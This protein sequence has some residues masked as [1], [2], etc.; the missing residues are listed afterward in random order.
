M[1]N[2]NNIKTKLKWKTDLNKSVI[3]ENLHERGWVETD[4]E[5]D[6]NFYWASINNIRNIYNAKTFYKLSN[7]QILNHFP[8]F[9]ELTRKD[10]MAKNMKKYRK[11]LL[12]DNVIKSEDQ[13]DF[14]PP[15]Y[16]L[17]G[18]YIKKVI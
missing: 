15:T 14:I 16:I 3:L 10:C 17:P 6:W 9:Y 8:N 7:G 2:S 1:E 4:S 11:Q 13:F 12:R 5:E 18:K